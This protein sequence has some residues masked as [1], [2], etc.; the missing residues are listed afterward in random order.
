MSSLFVLSG[1]T[2]C[3]TI[4]EDR[5]KV[6]SFFWTY[7][8][9]KALSKSSV[10]CG[11][12]LIMSFAQLTVGS[13]NNDLSTTKDNPR[14]GC[15]QNSICLTGCVMQSHRPRGH[16]RP[17]Y[18]T[19]A[20]FS[21][22]TPQTDGWCKYLHSRILGI[23]VHGVLSVHYIWVLLT[24]FLSIIHCHCCVDKSGTF[25]HVRRAVPLIQS[26]ISQVH[27]G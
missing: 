9:N 10:S 7:S 4:R 27:G 24:Q 2:L 23:F 11:L 3:C 1:T 18:F 26:W 13:H 8:K 16:S 14:V 17:S 12:W 25:L 6:K 22:T 20:L 21:P 15:C 5:S 19:S